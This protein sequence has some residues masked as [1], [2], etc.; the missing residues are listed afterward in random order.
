ML[1]R[2][3]SEGDRFLASEQERLRALPLSSKSDAE[4]WRPE[5]AALE[6]QLTTRFPDLEFP[7]EIWHYLSDADIRAREPE[8]EAMQEQVVTDYITSVR[9]LGC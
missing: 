8:Y 1:E 6:R 3:M 9:G 4:V 5:A 7:H 2:A